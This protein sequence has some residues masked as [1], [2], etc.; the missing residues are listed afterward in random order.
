[1][2]H[3]LTRASILEANDRPMKEIAVPEWGGHVYIRMMSAGERDAFE[4]AQESNPAPYRDLR[5]RLAVAT[6]CDTDGELLFTPDD[7]PALTAKSGRALDRIFA[8]AS[9]HNGLTKA[10]VDEL[11]K[12]S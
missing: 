12:N 4:G 5:A 8:A 7:V 10:D 1:M 3:Q 6:V 9:K 11:R 2:A